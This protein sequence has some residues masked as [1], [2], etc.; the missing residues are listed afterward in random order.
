M[1]KNYFDESYINGFKKESGYSEESL[2]VMVMNNAGSFGKYFLF[3]AFSYLSLKQYN[4]SVEDKGLLFIQRNVWTSQ[5]EKDKLTFLEH[6]EIESIVLHPGVTRHKLVIRDRSGKKLVFLVNKNGKP[7]HK[8]NLL[9]L[10]ERYG[11]Q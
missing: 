2:N 3:G 1:K 11:K 5:L 9:K 7:W 6:R 8:E 10:R 4:F